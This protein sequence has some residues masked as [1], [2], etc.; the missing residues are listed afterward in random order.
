MEKNFNAYNKR[1]TFLGD[2]ITN[3]GLYIAYLEA[4]FLEHLPNLKPSFVNLGVS[5]ETASGLSE[6]D[7]P[8]KRA[9]VHTRLVKALVESNPEIVVVCYGMNDGIYY[10]F[11]EE[12]FEAYKTG[13]LK[14]VEVVKETGRKIVLI[15][16]PIF[17]GKSFGE[18]NLLPEG[19]E[20]YSFMK[21]YKDYNQV[22]KKYS[23][24]I[25]TLDNTVD[26][27]VDI[28]TPME[29]SLKV[30]REKNPD[31]K[32][33]DGIH[34]TEIGHFVI[35]KEL[36]KS[37]FNISIT[38]VL[39]FVNETNSPEWFNV[40]LERHKIL[41]ASWRNHIGHGNPWRDDNAPLLEDAKKLADKLEFKAKRLL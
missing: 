6:P 25:K 18:E 41:S 33:G 32:H 12:R 16:P 30:E 17:D 24:W 7:H 11:S 22:L 31:Y 20:K 34:P 36:L 9:C 27:V 40:L 38:N 13:I 28:N 21:V 8:W 2:S 10:P 4:Y 37:L 14:L 26:I 5:S 1:I 23:Q 15:T 3:N 19:A 29:E 35:A 39:D